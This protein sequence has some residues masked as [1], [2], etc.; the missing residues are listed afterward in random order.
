MSVLTVREMGDQ[1][2]TPYRGFDRGA[3][4]VGTLHA[5]FEATG[6]GSGGTIIVQ[7]NMNFEEFGFHPIWVPTRV[8]SRDDQA[9]ATDVLMTYLNTG[10]ERLQTVVDERQLAVILN[11]VNRAEFDKLSIPIEPIR[12][13]GVVLQGFWLANVNAKVYHIHAFGPIYDAEALARGKK[14]GKAPD[15]LLAGIR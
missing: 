1:L 7:L 5:D 15:M 3:G 9:A 14:E 12:G 13:G 2:Y 11:G 10:N 6:D 8:G 4:V